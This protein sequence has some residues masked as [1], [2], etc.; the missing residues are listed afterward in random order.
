MVRWLAL[1]F[2][3]ALCPVFGRIRFENVAPRAGLDFRLANGAGGMFHQIE[4]MLAGVAAFD[5]NNDGCTDIFFINGAAIPSFQK[6]SPEFHNRLYKN[7]CD[8]TFADVT[9][10]AGVAGEGYSMAVATADY[11]NDGRVDVVV[12]SLNA[13]AKLFRNV[14]PGSAHWIAFRLEGTRATGTASG[15]L[16]A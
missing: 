10:T 12:N 5:Y 7:N 11:D 16:C 8:M 15:P 6:E 3:V 4:L 1:L 2:C 14:T 13:P 9:G